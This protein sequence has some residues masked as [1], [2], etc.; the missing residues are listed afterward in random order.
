[1]TMIRLL[2][3]FITLLGAA[4]AELKGC[5]PTKILGDGFNADFYHYPHGDLSFNNDP[6]AVYNGEIYGFG[7][8]TSNFSLA[9]GGYFLAPQSGDYTFHMYADDG[10]YLQFGAGDS[11]CGNAL[12]DVAGQS[13][14]AS[15]PQNA[16]AVFTLQQGV[17][18]P[19]KIV[20]VNFDGPGGFSL[21][22][23]APD[24]TTVDDMG[25]D[26]HQLRQICTRTTT[27][28]W[29]GT[30]TQTVTQTGD[31]SI[32][33]VVDV[34]TPTQTVSSYWTGSGTSYSTITGGAGQSNTLVVN[35]PAT[36]T[37]S[38]WSNTYTGTTTVTP[39]N[40]GQPT[41]VVEKPSQGLLKG[42][43]PTK[44]LGDGFNADFYH[45][46]HG[47]LSFNND[48]QYY[49]SSYKN[50]GYLGTASNVKKVNFQADAPYRAVYNGEI[51]GFGVTTSNF[52]L[53]IG[54]Y[55]LAPQSGDYTFHMYA[56]DGAYLQFGAG[57]SC[58]GNALDDVEG[59]SFKA[60]YPQNANAVFTLQQGV[61][62]PVK[63]VLVNF[64]GPGGFSLG[65]TA[66]D[67]TTVDDMGGDVHQLR[68]ICTR[69][70][71]ATWTGTDTQTVTQTGDDSITVV[72]DVPTPTQTVSSYWT[73]SGTSY[74][75]ITGGAGQSNTLVVNLPATTTT[76]F[77]SNTYTGTT[78]VTPANGGQPTVVVEKPSQGL[79]KGCNPTKI[80][81]DGFN[82]DF[83]HYPHG[84]LSFNNDPQYYRS[85][86]KNFGY[87]G[88]A[89]NVKKVNF[90]ADAPYRAV[91]NGE[92]YGFGVTTSNFSLAIGGYFLAPQSGDYTFHMYAD[93]GAYLQFGAGDSCCGNALDDVEGQSF[94]ASYPQN[95]N[96]VFTLQQGV[97][98]PV[99][100][101]LVNFDG[102]GG[103]SLGYT[104]P[105][106][107]TVDDM[108]GDVHQLRQICTRTTTATWTGTDTQ[109]VTQTGDD[110]ITVVVDVPTPT[111][112]VSS[113]W[114]GSGTS[115][116]T[117]TGGAGQKQH[118]GR[119]T[120]Q[121]TTTTSFWSNTYT[122]TTTVT[123]AN[124]GQPTVVVE[125]ASAGLLKGCN[126]TKILGD[127]FNADFT[128]ISWRTFHS[129]TILNTTV[130]ATRT[131]GCPGTAS[132]V[133]RSISKSMLLAAGQCTT[134][135]KS[136]GLVVTTSTSRWP[137]EGYFWLP[138]EVVT[139]FPH[140]VL[141]NFD[142][143]GGFSL[144]YTA[145]DGTTVDD[146]G[147]DV[148]HGSSNLYWTGSGTSYS[149]ITGGAGQSNT[150]VV[151][152]PA[153]TT[154]SFWSNTYTGTTTVTPANGG[155][156]TVVVEEPFATLT[157]YWTNTYASTTTV[158]RADGE[159][160]TV[161]IER[162][163]VPYTTSTWTGSAATTV[164]S[165]GTDG[166]ETVVVKLPVVTKTWTGS[167]ATTTTSTGTDGLETVVVD[168]PN[169]PYTTSTWTGS[170]AT[171]VTSTGTDGSETVV[172]EL[173]V[174]TKTWTGSYATTTTST[175]TD[176][177]ETVVVE[178]PVVTKTWTGSYATTTTSTGTDGLETVVVDRP[179]VPYTTSTWTGSVATTVTS[180]GTDGSETVV[181]ELPVVTKTWTG[182]YATTTTSTGTDGLETVVLL[183]I[184]LMFH[185]L[186]SDG[187]VAT[188]VTSTG[189]DG[190]ETIVVELPVAK[191]TWTGSAATW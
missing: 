185:H 19:V 51:Y 56:D 152:L 141:V 165:T 148:H 2:V 132:N 145:P 72:V 29:T 175:G 128:I 78:T 186:D 147:G 76:S 7:V 159:K 105:D 5:N 9:I 21:G 100:I 33:V 164:T 35:L 40:G 43:N 174:V 82:A 187:S 179:N 44:I 129:T 104:A 172:V 81:G 83:Y 58:C 140:I 30:D 75:T 26:V 127:G 85:S 99:K 169:V 135:V 118:F 11:C 86:Y 189:T 93:D 121:L 8:T 173:P 15:Y 38:F 54:G 146:T 6:Q 64:D 62:Y 120:C 69:T 154:T 68:Q 84:D 138:P 71:T 155:Q 124:G 103:F 67:G 97:Y 41:V 116:S 139:T 125:E 181:V 57:D 94:K 106:G 177:S 167:Y 31:D 52:S 156:P 89:S 74:S 50:F 60:S 153:T 183:L 10:A 171:T 134:M 63:I 36:T 163:P 108:G 158:A 46:P 117:I 157:S 136:M 70:T 66:P 168:R 48:P 1:M 184:V 45:Y 161:V 23:T 102:P 34:P 142:G 90:Q 77:W 162:P 170:V 22:Y 28:T 123:P 42:C 59:Q 47:D 101:V 178:L 114:T 96:A 25:G 61:Y 188:T 137:L 13:F 4:L 18:Y 32:T 55:F 98:Y 49:R 150:L 87:L 109:T 91:Y 126:P 92:I 65:Y 160:P 53:A 191:S 20:L 119:S 88:T 107:T 3:A 12:D 79:L 17:Y 166:S 16:N 73:G 176:G 190:S 37:T 39:A 143:P 133:K 130:R 80:L 149:T 182:S 112:T 27:A 14:K 151:N 95:A 180:T 110:S 111:Q 24:G 131:F 122:G 144:G 113:Y 115:Y